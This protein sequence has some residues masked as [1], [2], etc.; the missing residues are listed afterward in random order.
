MYIPINM[1]MC[2]HHATENG[3]NKRICGCDKRE[4]LNI[5]EILQIQYV[6]V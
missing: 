5:K 3:L 6:E 1:S 4:R 2:V